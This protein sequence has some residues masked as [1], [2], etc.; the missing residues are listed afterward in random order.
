MTRPLPL[1]VFGKF[2][3]S[4]KFWGCIFFILFYSLGTHGQNTTIDSLLREYENTE[5][6]GEKVSLHKVILR[7]YLG[8]DLQKAEAHNLSLIRYGERMD[9]DSIIYYGSLYM[10]YV[11]KIKA[12]FDSALIYLNTS[13]EKAQKLGDV[14][15]EIESNG[16][17]G[18]VYLYRDNKEKGFSI[19][20]KSIELAQSIDNF[21][22]IGDSYFS[23]AMAYGRYNMHDSSLFYY[24]LADSVYIKM[25]EPD[26]NH[27]IAL[28]NMGTIHL[29]QKNYPKS[30]AL[31]RR[32]LSMSK[33][34]NHTFS[35]NMSYFRLAEL[36][37]QLEQPD[38]TR[39]YLNL[40]IPFF[41][42]QKI[43]HRL[44]ES[45][46]LFGSSLIDEG[47]AGDAESYIRESLGYAVQMQDSS[48]MSE[49]NELLGRIYE[50]LND[51][52]RA[53]KHY[54]KAFSLAQKTELL[55]IQKE[56]SRGLSVAYEQENDLQK[57]LDYSKVFKKLD[58]SLS[59]LRKEE[60]VLEL[61]EKYE[62][63]KREK[64]I[65]A[66]NSEKNL[67]EQKRRNQL[68]I[69]LFS[70]VSVL[71]LTIVVWTLYRARSIKNKKLKE[72]DKIKNKFFGNISHE[73]RT[74]L[75]II[76]GLSQNL[77]DEG[78]LDKEDEEKVDDIK[79]N[80]NRLDFLANQILTLNAIDSNSL[81]INLVQSDIIKFLK[82]YI[83]LFKSFTRSNDQEL[84]LKIHC[85]KLIMDF[86]PNHL[87]TI[88]NNILG[89]AIKFS[90]E[91][92][93][94]TVDISKH[95]QELLIQVKDE[96]PGIPESKIKDIFN[97]YYTQ[98]HSE[99]DGL[100]I[101]LSL[102]KELTEEMGGA[103]E[104]SQ[105]KKIGATFLVRLPIKSEGA[106][107][108]PIELHMP[109]VEKRTSRDIEKSASGKRDKTILI[110]E[111]DIGIQNYLKSLFQNEYNCRA[112]SNG[113]EALETINESPV[114]FIIS[115][116]VMPRMDGI[117]LCKKVKGDIRYSHIPFIMLSAKNA[118]KE[119]RESYEAGADLFLSKPFDKRR[120]E[121]I[122]ENLIEKQEKLKT[123]FSNLL[124]KPEDDLETEEEFIGEKDYDFIISIQEWALRESENSS[125]SDLT[126]KM[127]MSRTSLHNK[128]KALTGRSTT[129]YVNWIK[130]ERSKELI[131]SNNYSLKEIAYRLGFSDPSYFSRVFKNISGQSP[132]DFSNK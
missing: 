27:A 112:A 130:I 55:Q 125:V 38:S 5:N 3:S 28:S 40:C 83:L 73:L 50:Q 116:L 121:I 99:R 122:I 82:E 35:E 128:I 36:Y 117:T 54:S 39:F 94:I 63:A 77:V 12:E 115:D 18:D 30:K 59:N 13:L 62:N 100:G 26:I 46:M 53:I 48:K 74:P 65:T 104:A 105:N 43:I 86:D 49:C 52:K 129:E 75:T 93:E 6:L 10:G 70:L 9:N 103:V 78:R 89:N 85:D 64:E 71:A 113:S 127:G 32:C 97:R 20:R 8:G 106:S 126:K 114:D 68:L 57:A 80:A 79:K 14:E 81:Q 131:Q 76:K 91:S 119:I 110:V 92:S 120:L 47:K 111:D 21:S 16:F 41:E 42:S 69:F 11:K 132:S 19:A 101:G 118:D 34:L 24:Q 58:D 2:I 31:F 124:R 90:P 98:S 66:L 95:S 107:A 51:F 109:F 87:Q 96:G 17:L 102:V 33:S 37:D 72:V 60:K 25:E 84:I 123:Y 22:L 7:E 45:K 29:M 15:K 23:L 108:Q 67:I 56:A 61:Q 4:L 1:F 44:A 88:L